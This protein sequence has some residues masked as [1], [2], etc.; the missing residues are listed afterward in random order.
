MEENIL[1]VFR[2]A[3]DNDELT[4]STSTRTSTTTSTTTMTT[5]TKKSAILGQPFIENPFVL[6]VRMIYYRSYQC[7]GVTPYT[8]QMGYLNRL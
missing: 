7:G 1:D 4:T 2:R 3:L 5:K 6:C 8:A